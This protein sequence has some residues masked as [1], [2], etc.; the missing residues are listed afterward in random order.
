MRTTIS[1][2]LFAVALVLAAAGG[3]GQEQ[4]GGP[5]QGS[6][7]EARPAA[8]PQGGPSGQPP[9]AA[10]APGLRGRAGLT[11]EIGAQIDS[12]NAAY[13]AKDFEEALRHY[14][15]VTELD[16]GIAAGWFGV[17]MAEKELGHD[18]EATSA[19]ERA[20]RAAPAVGAAHSATTP[21][22]GTP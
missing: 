8:E 9:A 4:R 17:Y 16:E 18:D 21:P 11:A 19:L 12:G 7:A 2:A 10:R 6:A 13:R 14:R 20:R 3:C 1:A 22:G 5:S 15:T